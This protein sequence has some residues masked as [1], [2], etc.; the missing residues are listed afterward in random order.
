M[1][2]ASSFY[3]VLK[4]KQAWRRVYILGLLLWRMIVYTACFTAEEMGMQ[5]FPLLEMRDC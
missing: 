2:N 1:F 3:F 4:D 5:V